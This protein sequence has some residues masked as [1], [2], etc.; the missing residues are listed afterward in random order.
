LCTWPR[1]RQRD[2][3]CACIVGRNMGVEPGR[4]E[5]ALAIIQG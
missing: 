3:V 4:K 2:A 1:V 5:H